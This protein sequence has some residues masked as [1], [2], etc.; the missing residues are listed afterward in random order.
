MTSRSVSGPGLQKFVESIGDDFLEVGQPVARMERSDAPL[1]GWLYIPGGPGKDVQP[2]MQVRLSL[3]NAPSSAFGFLLGE[4]VTVSEFPVSKDRI[5]SLLESD[6]LADDILGSGNMVE[7]RIKLL[8]DAST[9]SGFEW[10]EGGGAP[11]R[12][13]AGTIFSGAI[14]V[15]S[16]APYTLLI[17]TG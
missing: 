15:R 12:I 3:E 8:A 7:V 10:T 16:Q 17:P 6:D 5:L 14:I 1:E 9:L 2:G 11:F 4:V 13:A